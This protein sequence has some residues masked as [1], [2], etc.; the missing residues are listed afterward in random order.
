MS[1]AMLSEVLSEQMGSLMQT[2]PPTVAAA[3]SSA[4][5][6]RELFNRRLYKVIFFL[7]FG[8]VLRNQG[9]VKK[10][11]LCNQSLYLT[12]TLGCAQNMNAD[13]ITYGTVADNI[14]F[15]LARAS[16]IIP[17]LGRI[18]KGKNDLIFK[19]HIRH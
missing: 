2:L 12:A 3:A 10:C 11:I 18:K 8:T 5:S 9:V 4:S 16:F 14:G 19:Y 13:P 7:G 17:R 1:G 15:S 6:S